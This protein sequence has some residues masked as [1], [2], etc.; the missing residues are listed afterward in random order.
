[1]HIGKRLKL[2][3]KLHNLTQE[4]MAKRTGL[5]RTYISD[6]ENERYGVTVATV[7]NI[8]EIFDM[9]MAELYDLKERE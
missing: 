9:S 8:I 2:L 3:R 1:M 7:E 6:L 4:E 5:S